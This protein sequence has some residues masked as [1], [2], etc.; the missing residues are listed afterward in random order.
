MGSSQQTADF[1][2]E[3]MAGAGTVSAKKMFGE[4][5][6]YCDGKVVGLICDDQLFVK[7]TAAGE[8]AIGE[9]TLAPPY[10]GAKGYFSIADEY[11][12]DPVWLAALIRATADA[13]PLP[14]PRKPKV[15]RAK[16]FRD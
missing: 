12:D 2:I 5:S 14:T 13:L 3:Q 1:L 11:W 4:Y 15:R 6:I 10:P 16:G 9:P 8:A 7:P